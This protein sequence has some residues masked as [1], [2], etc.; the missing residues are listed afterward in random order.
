MN[1]TRLIKT[2]RNDTYNKPIEINI[3]LISFP[4]QNVLKEEDAL[5]PLLFSFALEYAI[6][7]VLK[8]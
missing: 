1:L 5:P 7:K 4:I 6:R 3:C 8:I 2:C